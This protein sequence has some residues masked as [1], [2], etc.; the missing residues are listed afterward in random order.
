L[1]EAIELIFSHRGRSSLPSDH[2]S[3]DD[4]LAC[5]LMHKKEQLSSRRY[6]WQGGLMGT[7]A[8]HRA[9]TSPRFVIPGRRRLNM[10]L[11]VD[12][13]SGGRCNSP[14]AAIS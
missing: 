6:H 12:F 4:L 3:I 8:D 9:F 13:G 2:Q 11:A 5:A 7:A 14:E 1:G 10:S